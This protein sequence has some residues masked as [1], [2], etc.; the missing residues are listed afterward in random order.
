MGLGE[1]I[2]AI[3][4]IGNSRAWLITNPQSSTPT[5]I[6]C[7]PCFITNW[8]SDI[9]KHSQAGALQAKTY[10]YPTHHSLS[11]ANI[12]KWDIVLTSYNTITQQLK[13]TNTSTSRIF[14]ITW[15]CIILDEAQ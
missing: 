7:P 14:K 11:E 5:I 10:L 4:L 3:A 13:R 6:I 1:T 9:S 8:K 2:Q 15:Q 12:L